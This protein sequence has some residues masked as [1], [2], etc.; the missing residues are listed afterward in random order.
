[1]TTEEQHQR[2]RELE[3]ALEDC[4]RELE[5]TKRQLQDVSFYQKIFD[6]LPISLILFRPDGHLVTVNRAHEEM[7]GVPRD[8]LV[9]TYNIYE[10]PT[11]ATYNVVESFRRVC[12]GETVVNHP[13]PYLVTTP[14]SEQTEERWTETTCM[15]IFRDDT[16]DDGQPEVQYVFAVSTDV[17]RQYQAEQGFHQSYEA[18]RII[19]DSLDA[20][21][22]VSDMETY[23]LL[24]MNKFGQEAFGNA[25]GRTCWEVMQEKEEVCEFCT[26]DKLLDEHGNPTGIHRWEYFNPTAQRW[27]NISDRAI[28]WV[29]GRTVRMEIAM[30]VHELK[31]K[32]HQR[33]I[34]YT[35][36]EGAPDGIIVVDSDGHILYSN[37]AYR[38]MV[39]VNDTSGKRGM[40]FLPPEERHSLSTILHE[41][42]EKQQQWQGR[43]L[44]QRA[45]GTSFPTQVSIFSI[46]SEERDIIG[47]AAIIRDISAVEEAEE[48]RLTLKE[49]IIEAQ[50]DSLRE[51]STPLIPIAD[52][53]LVMP[54]IGSIDTARAQQVMESLLEGIAAH[55]ADYAI[56]DITG[57]SVVDTQVANTI[58]TIAQAVTLLGAQI[59]LTGIQPT[60][61]QTLVS[62]GVD[63]QSIITRS[64]LQS[65]IRYVTET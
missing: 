56:V 61:A 2:I 31:E 48:E 5:T 23:K 1:M 18:F 20:L 16:A 41:V 14:V 15:P 17:T 63:L 60:M 10:D 39:G 65:G 36:A 3:K 24:F 13:S 54:L 42:E 34:F 51:L 58:V 26:N 52:N 25:E 57:V 19:L 59:I 8:E 38:Q 28:T 37:T 29:D 43:V 11:A 50:R 7:V 9:G 21:V 45:D 53:L 46:A 44:H 22:Y 33:R 35:L 6:N 49:R 27:F 30:D 4:T 32:E 64:T 40:D 47:R 12:Q 55:Q 62:L